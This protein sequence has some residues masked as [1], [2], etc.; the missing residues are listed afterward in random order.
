[1]AGLLYGALAVCVGYFLGV[2][3]FKVS[4]I[5]AYSELLPFSWKIADYTHPKKS[6]E[7][8]YA[9][10]LLIPLTVIVFALWRLSTQNRFFFLHFKGIGRT[11]SG[12]S[13]H[14]KIVPDKPRETDKTAVTFKSKIGTCIELLLLFAAAAGIVIHFSHSE[15]KILFEVDYYLAN[16]DW[17]KVIETGQRYQNNDHIIHA[18]NRALY[19]LGLLPSD[20]FCYKQSQRSFMLAAK[21]EFHSPWNKIGTYYD[22]GAVNKCECV[23]I[24][25]VEKYDERPELL[26][27]LA[28]VRIAKGDIH[29]ARVYL[30]ALNKTLFYSGWAGDCLKRLDADP[31]MS[32][33]EEIQHLRSSILHED[34]G[35]LEFSIE[36][37]LINLLKTNPKNQ[38]A[39]EYLMAFYMLQYDVESFVQNT[40]R[41]D[42]F[43][44]PQIPRHYEEAIVSY[45]YKV[46]KVPVV[47]GRSIST[48]SLQQFREFMQIA[49]RYGNNR[50]AAFN[51]LAKY[52]GDTYYFYHVYGVSGLQN[53]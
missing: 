5:D 35:E 4:I 32:G 8:I 38:M 16:K 43:N 14:K 48:K 15:R 27:K 24:D 37:L 41:L 25:S 28:I 19:H 26:K 11:K 9:L 33:D 12:K 34:K 53:E 30:E 50:Q 29:S 40:G 18:M 23:L 42:D 2:L 3:L 7:A 45:I 1:M 52:Y 49:E 17:K 47:K 44:Y 21:K 46:K 20:M 31:N 6:I 10:Y 39:F 51:E 36:E 13:K 22:L